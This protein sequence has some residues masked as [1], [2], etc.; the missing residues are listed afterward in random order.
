[1]SATRKKDGV[2]VRFLSKARSVSSEIPARVASADCER[3]AFWRAT[4][5]AA[6]RRRPRSR[7]AF[8]KAGRG[9]TTPV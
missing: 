1:M 5:R 8:V 4:D 6:L 2:A 7:S 3:S 9:I